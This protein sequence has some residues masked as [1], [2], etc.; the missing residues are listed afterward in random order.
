MSSRDVR[1]PALP[2]VYVVCSPA[3]I[4]IIVVIIIAATVVNAI[5]IIIITI[6][7]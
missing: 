4:P 6:T 2:A 1:D 5:I 7:L 3:T